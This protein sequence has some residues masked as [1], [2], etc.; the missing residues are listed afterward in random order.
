MCRWELFTAYGALPAG[1]RCAGDMA[2][3]RRPG[4]PHGAGNAGRL[5]QDTLCF[6]D[7]ARSLGALARAAMTCTCLV[8]RMPASSLWVCLQHVL[9][10]IHWQRRLMVGGC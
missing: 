9:T 8:Q 2:A 3:G 4:G 7:Q 6:L 10:S 5:A 1:R